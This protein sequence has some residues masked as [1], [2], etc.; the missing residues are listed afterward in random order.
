MCMCD[1][2]PPAGP[3]LSQPLK[4]LMTIR[5]SSGFSHLRP[6]VFP[7]SLRTQNTTYT[8]KENKQTRTWVSSKRK[9]G[10]V[11]DTFL[12]FCE[13]SRAC[14]RAKFPQSH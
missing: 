11:C 10:E 13:L 3:P 9:K 4:P 8:R 14:I 2:T 1:N 7:I 12:A 5:S 6:A